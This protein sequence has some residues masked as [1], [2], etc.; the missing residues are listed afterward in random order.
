[1]PLAWQDAL[2]APHCYLTR[3]DGHASQAPAAVTTQKLQVE[4]ELRFEV[5]YGAQ[6]EVK[7][8][9]ACHHAWALATCGVS[10]ACRHRRDRPAT[11]ARGRGRAVWDG[12]GD[13]A[14]LRLHR[15]QGGHL[16]VA[17]L[18]VAGWVPARV[19][20]LGAGRHQTNRPMS[21]AGR[22]GVAD[23]RQAAAHVRGRRDADGELPEPPPRAGQPANSGRCLGSERAP[24]TPA[25]AAWLEPTL[26]SG[27]AD[28]FVV[29][30][31]VPSGLRQVVIAGPTDV[32]KSTLCRLLLN[33]AVRAHR[34]PLFVDLDVGQVLCWT[35]A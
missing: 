29:W 5:D 34:Q 1:M 27:H 8:R 24:C 14:G 28:I 35:G 31:G 26:P 10:T 17:R 16:Y 33:Y 4:Q 11:A 32:G 25:D 3:A 18:R 13:E 20:Q 22:C 21:A 23:H 15:V 7:V 9:C 6:V 2:T 30:V 12:A 19:L